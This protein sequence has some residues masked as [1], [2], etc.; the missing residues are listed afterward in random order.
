[1]NLTPTNKQLAAIYVKAAEIV[2]RDAESAKHDRYAKKPRACW[3]IQEAQG[4]GYYTSSYA[5]EQY[6][7][8]MLA[9]R[10]VSSRLYGTACD[11][12]RGH[13]A[14]VLALLLMAE[15]VKDNADRDDSFFRGPTYG[16][17]T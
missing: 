14:R 10:T 7:G 2:A 3:A 8:F 4:M 13:S 1:M 15:V 6:V 17:C 11:T 9:G 5:R 16:V 12:Q